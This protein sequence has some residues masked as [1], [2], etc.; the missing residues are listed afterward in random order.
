M[1]EERDEQC[2]EEPKRES[3]QGED[4]DAAAGDAAAGD[5]AAE[6]PE[7]LTVREAA[8]LIGVHFNAVYGAVRA[9]RLRS[10]RLL[11]KVAILPADALAFAETVRPNAR[12]HERRMLR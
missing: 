7:Y 8:A 12:R 3:E 10:K 6:E 5:A 2:D 9:K 1:P 11:G 4:G